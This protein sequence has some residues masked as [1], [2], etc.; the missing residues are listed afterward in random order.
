MDK[1]NFFPT[2][3]E[4]KKEVREKEKLT[5][6]LEKKH[7]WSPLKNFTWEDSALGY[8]STR[9]SFEF[10]SSFQNFFA[11]VLPESEKSLRNY[12][13]KILEGR[14]G[15]AIGVEF[16]GT[17][18]TLFRGFTPNFFRQTVGVTLIDYKKYP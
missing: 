16:G 14:K 13:E 15:K 3:Q 18:V 8:K 6:A 12:I 10:Y 9:D 11:A 7:H 4:R 5:Q 17:G 2:G 1:L